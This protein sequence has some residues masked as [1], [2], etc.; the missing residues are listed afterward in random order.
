[1]LHVRAITLSAYVDVARFLGLDGYALLT[2]FGIAPS[3]LNEPDN[4]L[5]VAA[6][7]RLL[8]RS[9]EKSGI[10][11][12]GIRL[13]EC[14]SFASI[15]VLSLLLQHLATVRDVVEALTRYH[16]NLSNVLLIRLDEEEDFALITVNLAP[17]GDS[18]QTADL[19]LA[20]AYMILTG[21]SQG[22]WLPE[23]VHFTRGRPR[24]AAYFARYFRAPLEF[25]SGF[26]GFSCS[27]RS[28]DIPLP[29][30]D[31]AMAANAAR[32]LA[33]YV[34]F[35]SSSAGQ[36]VRQTI[37]LMLPSGRASLKAV[38]ANLSLS[39]RSLQRLLAS[40]GFGFA[41]LLDEVRSEL[42]KKY[43]SNPARPL[44]EIADD[45]GYAKLSSFTRWFTNEFGQPPSEWRRSQ[46][47]I[48]A[49]PPPIWKIG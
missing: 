15:G 6:I 20:L 14:R 42:A 24:D 29:L 43:L 38:A 25:G 18:D 9:A 8:E 2:Q 39:E 13:A 46:L 48:A 1:V 21:A 10:D 37:A 49:S 7:V 22:R 26:T 19:S 40:E 4:L 34:P 41:G 36:H 33:T 44:T 27:R 32:L 23:T 31:P 45:L 11:S 30:A 17:E 12:F 35:E 16:R 28:L 47:S 3:A 5:P